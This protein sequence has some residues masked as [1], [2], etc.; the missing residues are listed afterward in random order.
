MH[1]SLY[2]LSFIGYL[3]ISQVFLSLRGA[4]ISVFESTEDNGTY[5]CNDNYV[6]YG[7]H[8][9]INMNTNK[10]ENE[11]DTIGPKVP[12]PQ[13]LT[14]ILHKTTLHRSHVS[15][16]NPSHPSSKEQDD[17]FLIQLLISELPIISAYNDNETTNKTN[18]KNGSKSVSINAELNDITFNLDPT[19]TC[20]PTITELLTP[21]TPKQIITTQKINQIQKNKN[22]IPNLIRK[23]N[24]PHNSEIEKQANNQFLI[25]KLNVQIKQCLFDYIA[26]IVQS[27]SLISISLITISSTIVSNSKILSMKFNMKNLAVHL[28]NRIFRN[29]VIEQ[30]PLNINGIRIHDTI[31]INE[32]NININNDIYDKHYTDTSV[33]KSS[34]INFIENSPLNQYKSIDKRKNSVLDLDRYLDIH[35]LVQL[36]TVDHIEAKLSLNLDKINSNSDTDNDHSDDSTRIN[37][38]ADSG[39]SKFGTLPESKGSGP[40]ISVPI[41]SGPT[42]SVPIVSGPIISGPTISVPLISGPVPTASVPMISGP[43]ATGP[44][45]SKPI[46]TGPTISKPSHAGINMIK[47]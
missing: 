44:I 22:K 25:I 28:S 46:V 41:V 21:C 39:L 40:T 47:L 32:N 10:N 34:K 5:G 16:V 42:I 3:S 20:I 13:I 4:D 8:I 45:V 35:C 26:P 27:H 1:A 17:A 14:P 18:D 7:G 15:N 12:V 36:L 11:Y 2:N 29:P 37:R 23:P 38:R 33:Y 24:K 30:N 31:K 19:S 6:I 43:V 9:D